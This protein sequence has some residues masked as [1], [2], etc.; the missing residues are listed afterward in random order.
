MKNCDSSGHVTGKSVFLDDI[1]LINGTLHA[2]VFTSDIACGRLM[3][4]DI[5][6]A[7]LEQGVVRIFTASDI[8]GQNQIGGII[9][10]EPLFAENDVHFIGQPI[11]LVVARTP[12][13][14]INAR[15]LIKTE[16][17]PVEPVLDPRKAREMGRLLFP[18]RI[19]KMG[20]VAEIWEK[21]PHVFSGTAESG[22]QEHVY[23]ETQGAY[24]WPEENGCLKVCSSTQGLTLVQKIVAQVLGLPMHRIEVD[25]RRLGGGFGGKEDQATAW[26]VMTALAAFLLKKPVKLVLGRHD[27][28]I[29]T[30]K[31]HPYVADFTIGLSDDLKILGWEVTYLQNGGAASDLS[32]AIIERT[33]FH[34]TNSYFIPNVKA[35]AY[36]CKTNLPPNT[37][38]RGFG[39]PQ[40]MFVLESAIALAAGKLNIPARIIQEKNLVAENDRFPY[41]QVIK[42]PNAVKAWREACHIYD[43]DNQVKEIESFNNSTPFTKK[44]LALMPVCFGISFTNTRMNQARALV[45]VYQDGSIGV[46]TGAVE[47]GQGVNTRM[48]QVAA[49]VFSVFPER[50]KLETTNTTR[51]ANTSPTAA[52]AGADLNGKALQIACNKL[53]S[54]LKEN[55]R[56]MTGNPAAYISIINEKVYVDG[57]ET[58]ITWEKLVESAFFNRVNLSQSGHYATPVI[59]FNKSVEKGHPFAYYVF[60]TAIISVT[61]DCLR[62]RYFADKVQIV[63]D[64]GNSMNI[65]LDTGQVEGAVLQGIGWMTMEEIRYNEN[66]KL[67]SDTL[68]TYKVP[69]IYSAPGI[70]ECKALETEG[71]ELAIMKS[72]AV[73]EPPFVYGIGMYFALLNAIHAFN[74]SSGFG[75]SAPLTPEK[76]LLALY[77]RKHS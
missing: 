42:N 1:P 18:P 20:N 2:A 9:P 63:H 76:V 68:S 53:L 67:L 6:Q 56:K 26:A 25:V 13:D 32:P 31:R 33:L 72:K 48:K 35:T 44:G 28:M 29:M 11:A 45:H 61:L 65:A 17:E 14:A 46:S 55:A 51:V 4:L 21:C 27:D 12:Q 58:D 36:S 69:D 50:I 66:G 30:G 41:G 70:L 43:L 10:D 54:R 62:G 64:F 74:A 24:S 57:S 23:L 59:H 15:K 16:Y 22:A 71:P 52:S 3:S 60:G 77:D 73:G 47:M 5:S 34:S 19:F 7:L 49:E 38:F 75:F 39:A 40:A 37:A 8:P